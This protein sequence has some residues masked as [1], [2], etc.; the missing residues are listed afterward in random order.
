MILRRLILNK[1]FIIG[2]NILPKKY[3][4]LV[5]INNSVAIKKGKRVGTTLFAKSKSPFLTAK[6]L[7]FAKTSKQKVN[8]K[9]NN[10][11]KFLFNFITYILVLAIKS[12][13]LFI[14]I[15]IFIAK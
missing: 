6:I 3:K 7:L 1:G 12:P 2:F 5:C 10:G 4:I 15:N 8:N 14:F 9:N 13:N 11:K